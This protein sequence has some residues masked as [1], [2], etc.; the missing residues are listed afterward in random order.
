MVKTGAGY[1]SQSEMTLTFGLGKRETVDRVLVEWPSG[2]VEDYKNLKAGE[3]ECV[4]EKESS[5]YR[6][7]R[8][9][10]CDKQSNH[11]FYRRRPR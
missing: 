1:L 9:L 11:L 6:N 8:P 3:Y 10:A 5:R 7:S 4:E 2:R